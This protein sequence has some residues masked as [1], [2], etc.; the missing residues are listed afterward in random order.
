MALGGGDGL[1]AG[2]PVYLLFGPPGSGKGTLAQA[3]AAKL[4][5]PRLSTGDALRTMAEAD[6]QLA[7]G[8]A[9]G[10]LAADEVVTR[11]VERK[12]EDSS[13]RGGLILDGYPRTAVQAG[14]WNALRNVWR[15]HDLVIHLRVDYTRVVARMADRRVCPHCHRVYSLSANPPKVQDGSGEA[16]CVEDGWTLVRRAD[17]RA[18]VIRERWK[19]YE[20]MTSPALGVLQA[21]GRKVEEV[22]GNG[23]PQ[24]VLSRVLAVI[25]RE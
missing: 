16:R 15:F 25:G 18:E 12:L 17:D 20:E 14:S 24:E 1:Q 22:D 6:Q 23:E 4:K 3:L 11:I 21:S 2:A 19:A 9:D 7:L 13:S 5:I 10:R 8:L